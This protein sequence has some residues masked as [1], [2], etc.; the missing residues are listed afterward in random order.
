MSRHDCIGSRNRTA[1]AAALIALASLGA[2]N[3]ASAF[4]DS[5][6][7][8]LVNDIGDTSTVGLAGIRVDVPEGRASRTACAEA[9][10]VIDQACNGVKAL[11]TLTSSDRD[12][13]LS[14]SQD[15]SADQRVR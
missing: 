10:N 15:S 11:E 12:T 2:A 9:S 5:T 7:L 4:T 13:I 8:G 6:G 3:P 1:L 14:R